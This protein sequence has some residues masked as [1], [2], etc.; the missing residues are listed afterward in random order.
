[1]VSESTGNI[2]PA[3]KSRC[4]LIWIMAPT[5]DEIFNVLKK[6]TENE[7]LAKD[8]QI[9]SLLD[10][11]SKSSDNNLRRS[12]LEFQNKYLHQDFTTDDMI[13]IW[14]S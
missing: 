4:L 2:I 11:I 7:N 6:I 8:T 9:E 14:K 12:I 1:M 10:E 3:I 5:S 13:P